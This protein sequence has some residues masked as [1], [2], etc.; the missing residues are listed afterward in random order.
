MTTPTRHSVHDI[1]EQPDRELERAK[2]NLAAYRAGKA[3]DEQSQSPTGDP[4]AARHLSAE[5]HEVAARALE[6]AEQKDEA[7]SSWHRAACGHAR[8]NNAAGVIAAITHCERLANH[9]DFTPDLE[10]KSTGA[11]ADWRNGPIE[12]DR[13]PGCGPLEPA[14]ERDCRDWQKPTT[15]ATASADATDHSTPSERL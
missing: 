10:R 15:S 1:V 13:G 8:A 5:E 11:D 14:I 7:I 2:A 12:S 6:S 3:A 9:N 4:E